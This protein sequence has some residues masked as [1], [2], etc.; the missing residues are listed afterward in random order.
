MVKRVLC[1]AIVAACVLVAPSA[2]AATKGTCALQ[3]KANIPQGLTTTA[4]AIDFAF[5]GS[6]S[7]C[8]G[9]TGI[10]KGTVTASGAGTGSCSGNTTS[11]SATITWNTGQT[12]S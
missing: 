12:S 7:N 4:K 3:G 6:L 5:S 11:G 9:V 8:K 10:T 1:A 2:G